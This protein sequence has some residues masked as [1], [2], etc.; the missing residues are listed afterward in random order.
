MHTGPIR[1]RLLVWDQRGITPR[2]NLFFFPERNVLSGFFPLCLGWG[3][4][5]PLPTISAASTDQVFSPP[6]SHPDLKGLHGILSWLTSGVLK[7]YLRTMVSYVH[8]AKIQ[9]IFGGDPS[10]VARVAGPVGCLLRVP[11]FEVSSKEDQ[12]KITVC[13]VPETHV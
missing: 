12:K 9:H 6:F 1:E 8:Y 4:N 13:V 5:D 2:S 11:F 10:S 3:G 7:T